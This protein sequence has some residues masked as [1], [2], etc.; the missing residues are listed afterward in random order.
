M[1][2]YPR[3]YPVILPVQLPSAGRH[4][5]DPCNVQYTRVADLEMTKAALARGLLFSARK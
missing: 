3:T 5:S 2:A 4:L 1:P